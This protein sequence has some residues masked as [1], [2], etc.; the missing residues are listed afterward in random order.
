DLLIGDLI[1]RAPVVAGQ[2]SHVAGVGL[3]GACGPAT[4]GQVPD[5]FCSKWCHRPA[6][7]PAMNPFVGVSATQLREAASFNQT[8]DRMTRSAADHKLQS[9][10]RWRAP[11]HRSA[12][13]WT[14]G[15]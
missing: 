2:I 3:L 9:G 5:V 8:L 7:M 6:M 15:V 13:R 1:G 14:E 4:N 11:R 10:S 12:L